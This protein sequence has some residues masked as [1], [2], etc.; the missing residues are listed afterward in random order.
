MVPVA[1]GALHDDVIGPV[2]QAGVPD[3]GLVVVADVAGEDDLFLHAVLFQPHLHAG[4]AEQVACVHKANFYALAQLNDLAVLHR[5]Q[6]FRDLRG[7]GHGV[8]RLHRGPAGP[9]ALLVLP[10]GIHLLD[11]GRVLEHDGHQ[12]AG[13]AGGKDLPLKALL[14]EQGDAAGVVD[15]RVGDDHI[16]DVIRRKVQHGVVSLVLALLQAAVDEDLLA[17]DFHAVAAARDGLGR[18]EKGEFHVGFPPSFFQFLV[19]WRTAGRSPAAFVLYKVILSYPIFSDL[20]RG[21]GQVGEN[22]PVV[23]PPQL[24]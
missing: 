21:F 17:A 8:Q 10:L 6:V 13:Q 11:V 5:H 15:V 3:D 14:D 2:D 20:P 4:R 7:V 16:V 18:P 9:L 19:V 22:S 1:V 23:P 24:C 12:L